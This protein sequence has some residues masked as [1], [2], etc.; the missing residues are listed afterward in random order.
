MW[1]CYPE[2]VCSNIQGQDHATTL[3]HYYTFLQADLLHA[4]C[5]L[6]DSQGVE[7]LSTI[8]ATDVPIQAMHNVQRGLP[9]QSYS[10]ALCL[11]LPGLTTAAFQ[12]CLRSRVWQHTTPRLYGGHTQGY[13]TPGAGFPSEAG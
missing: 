7:V 2:G 4:C 12:T 10:V 6:F 8:H 9:S 3:G 13:C 1:K 11:A 5:D